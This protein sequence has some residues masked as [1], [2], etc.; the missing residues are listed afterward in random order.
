MFYIWLIIAVVLYFP[1]KKHPLTHN[2]P[3]AYALLWPLFL[4]LIIL[5]YLTSSLAANKIKM[6]QISEYELRECCKELG[7]SEKEYL[8]IINN[9]MLSVRMIASNL[10]NLDPR[11]KGLNMDQNTRLA[12][13]IYYISKK[14]NDWKQALWNWDDINNLSVFPRD[15]YELEAL[16]YLSFSSIL[17]F[18]EVKVSKIPPEVGKL[19]NLKALILGSVSTPEIF[20][21]DLIELPNEVCELY[22]LES[23]HLQFN[24]LRYLPANIGDLFSLKELKAGGNQ[25]RSLPDSISSLGQL[26]VLTLW[27]NDIKRLPTNIGYLTQLKGLDI[28]DNDLEE[29]P[30]SITK[31]TNLERFY[32]SGNENLVLSDNQREWI[33]SLA[34][35]GCEIYP[36]P[37]QLYANDY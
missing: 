34:Q 23:L 16:E 15:E 2:Y 36:A 20:A 22:K 12:S 35:S 19:S 4:V 31:L 6:S 9:K 11:L 18:D 13:A 7:I 10:E 24:S 21:T 26:E 5:N 32:Y 8:R 29:L 33:R 37:N 17:Y 14:D 3:I 25:L 1:L 27:Q 30:T 28:S